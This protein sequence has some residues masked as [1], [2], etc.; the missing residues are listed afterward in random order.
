M[1]ELARSFIGFK[2]YQKFTEIDLHPNNVCAIHIDHGYESHIIDG[3]NSGIYTSVMIDASHD[4]IEKNIQRT[5]LIVDK[6]HKKNISVE[7]EL[8]ILSGQEDDIDVDG[9]Q[10]NMSTVLTFTR[11]SLTNLQIKFDGHV[12]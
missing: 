1:K 12:D 4:P 10:T 11:K 2:H 3:I 8:G 7:A 9:I 5:K 6:A